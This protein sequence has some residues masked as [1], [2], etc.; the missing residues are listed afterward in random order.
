MR[1]PFW[2]ASDSL[3][4]L[5]CMEIWMIVTKGDIIRT[6]KLLNLYRLKESKEFRY[7]KLVPWDRKACHIVSLPSLFRYWKSRYFFI[8][9]DGWETFS[10]DLWGDIPR[11]LC[12]WGTP[13]LGVSSFIFFFFWRYLRLVHLTLTPR[14]S[15][16]LAT[17]AQPKLKNRYKN[18]VKSA[19]EYMRT[20][21]DFDKLIN[22][23]TLARHFLGLKPSPYVLRAIVE[24]KKVSACCLASSSFS[25][26][27]YC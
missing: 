5:S 8:S 12:R 1:L 6:D 10:D 20:I 15:L 22:P 9:G 25:F 19:T 11:L 7:Y 21:D 24:K 26:Q 3:S 16:F 2:A 23:K 13:K 4:I 14:I 27:L 18:C 17:K